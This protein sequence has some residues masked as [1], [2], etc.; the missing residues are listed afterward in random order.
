MTLEQR[1]REETPRDIVSVWSANPS[2][3]YPRA[4]NS[5]AFYQVVFDNSRSQMSI[6]AIGVLAS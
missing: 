1:R 2:G 6:A 5:R 4:A 3:G